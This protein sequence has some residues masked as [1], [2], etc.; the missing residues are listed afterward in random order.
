MIDSKPALSIRALALFTAILLTAC[1]G[2]AD[3]A[4]PVAAD[5][6]PV[7][8]TAEQAKTQCWMK[9]ENK[10]APRDLDKRL[11]LVDKCIDEKMKLM[12]PAQ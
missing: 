2:A 9:Y 7:P 12:P 3:Q 11:A 5:G 10:S 8:T 1:A 6:E 4:K